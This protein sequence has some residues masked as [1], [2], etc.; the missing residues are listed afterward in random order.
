MRAVR[1][2]PALCAVLCGLLYIA[3][4]LPLLSVAADDLRMAGVY[5]LD[6]FGAA[7]VV[8]HLYR[9]ETLDPGTYKY[10][11]LFYYLPMVALKFLGALGDVSER[12]IVVTLRGFCTLAGLG[13]LWMTYRIGLRVFNPVAASIAC[14]LLAVA[15]AFLR[16]SVESH[17]DLPQLFWVLCALLACCRLANEF[18]L[19]WILLASLFAG[20]AFG[21]KYIGIFLL[22][23]IALAASASRPGGVAQ[24]MN[25]W[26]LLRALLIVPCVF[27]LVFAFTTPYAVVR[28]GEFTDS[29]SAFKE[30]M[31]S[32]HVV[33]EDDRGIMWVGALAGILGRVGLLIFVCALGAASYSLSRGK[34]PMD[35]GILLVWIGVVLSYLVLEINVRRT[36]YL[37]P[38]LPVALLFVSDLVHRS[39]MWTRARLSERIPVLQVLLPLF[40]ALLL[41]EP[42]AGDAS[43]FRGRW[44]REKLSHEISAGKWIEATFPPERSVLY[45]AYA[46]VPPKFLKAVPT[47]IG[48]SYPMVNHLKP[49]LLVVREATASHYSDLGDTSRT[50]LGKDLFL[51]SHYFYRYLRAGHIPVYRLARDFGTVSVYE[52]TQAAPKGGQHS[53]PSWNE[54]VTHLFSDQLYGQPLAR[55]TMG[56]IHFRLGL[57]DQAIREYRLA[58]ELAPDYLPVVYKLGRAYL[59]SGKRGGGT[60]DYREATHF[61]ALAAHD[62]PGRDQTKSGTRIFPGRVFCRGH[63]G[64]KGSRRA[65]P[66]PEQRAFRPCTVLPGEQRLRSVGFRLHRGRQKIRSGCG[67]V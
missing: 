12:M 33:R 51:D 5:S 34:L 15:P 25:D 3:F 45:D 52:R 1:E 11:G 21:T 46:Y 64:G 19:R 42:L 49:D 14:V 23:V 16:W 18:R 62:G 48:Q 36:R 40:L 50:Q 66:R 35:R 6:E 2:W 13:C 37:L 10:G 7:T 47:A 44:K 8:R 61:D 57:N 56:D 43:F 32:G 60:G 20:L 31:E 38:I 9:G 39:M 59:R 27:A 4:T 54:R 55:E 53:A 26:G 67:G 63:F 24:Q 65:E 17:P 22:P 29:L 41:W 30:I 58:A 28:F